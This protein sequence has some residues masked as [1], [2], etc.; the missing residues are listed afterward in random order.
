MATDPLSVD[1]PTS[2][3]AGISE[4][5]S[6]RF[7]SAQQTNPKS[8]NHSLDH[9]H[10]SPNQEDM[11]KEI[12][13]EFKGATFLVDLTAD[14]APFHADSHSVEA[15][16]AHLR[17]QYGVTD[18]TLLSDEPSSKD[19]PRF[20]PGGFRREGDSYTPLR[21]FLNAI[22]DSTKNNTLPPTSRYLE[23][24]DFEDYGREM[25]DIYNS[26]R[27]LK[28][29]ALGVLP[30]PTTP[31][32]K[33]FW[34]A[35]AI[36]IEVKN[37]VTELIQQ[38][39]A[40]ARCYL[41][42]DRRRSFAPAI[43]F[44]HKSLEILFFTFHRSG[45]SSSGPISLRTLEGFQTVVKYMVGILSIPDERAFGLDMTRAGDVFRINDRDYDIVRS[46]CEHNCVRGRATAVYSLKC[47]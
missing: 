35:V 3:H 27:P 23:G 19:S 6:R 41:A 32:P 10:P 24:L 15:V 37:R 7:S 25:K 2:A 13:N 20:P 18:T 11:K 34:K 39:S 47:T 26:L 21:D 44:H 33:V 46:I 42:A 36:I 12:L 5:T 30:P 8:D 29:D 45:M 1:T 22:V 38:L 17:D 31:Q 40:Y 43:G 14:G 4:P 28:P 9:S 16:L